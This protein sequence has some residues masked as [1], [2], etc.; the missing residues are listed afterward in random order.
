MSNFFTILKAV[1]GNLMTA[2]APKAKEI[3][4]ERVTVKEVIEPDEI[5]PRPIHW[6]KSPNYRIK[7]DKKNTAIILHHTASFNFNGE[8]AWMQDPT[9]KVSAHYLIGRD[10]KIAQLVKDEHV[11]YHAGHS[12]LDGKKYVNNFSIGIELTGDTTKKPLTEEQWDS[13]VW[14]VKKLMKKHDIDAARVVDH[15]YIAPDRKVDLDPK[16]FDW[17][18][19]YKELE[20][21][22]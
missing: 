13:M 1:L 22:D 7:K 15:R 20:A 3:I 6:R 14:L 18:R 19:F 2:F 21:I 11:A 8:L 17:E 5:E 9:A 4:T 16:N 12:E 10:G